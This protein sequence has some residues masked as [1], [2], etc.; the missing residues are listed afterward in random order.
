MTTPEV[1]ESTVRAVDVSLGAGRTTLRVALVE[2]DGDSEPTIILASGF[3]GSSAFHRPD[4]LASS[5]I[6]IPVAAVADVVA[7]LQTLT[8][9]DP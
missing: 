3:G 6:R 2:H 4:W 9:A 7:A 8:E 5:P 1:R